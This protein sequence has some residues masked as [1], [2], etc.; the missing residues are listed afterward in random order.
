MALG[1]FQVA[2][3]CLESGTN[4]LPESAKIRKELQKAKAEMALVEKSKELLHNR[5]Y[6]AVK[7]LLKVHM[8]SSG[9]SNGE[10]G[11]V[12]DNIALLHVA[13]RADAYMGNMDASM[14]KV[15]RALRYNPNQ[16]DGLAVRGAILYLAGET[17][18]GLH[19]LQD[20]YGRDKENKSIKLELQQCH[21]THTSLSTGRSCVKRGRYL[22]A[23]EHFTAAM[24]E[25][26]L[27][28]EKTPLY[29]MVRCERAEAMMLS[30]NL[31]DAL[32][33]CED[34]IAAQPENAPAW[35]VRAEILISLGKAQEAQ[36][37]LMHIRRTWG[38]DDPTIEEGYR[39]VDFELR[40]LKAE[41][42]L[43]RFVLTLDQEL[44]QVRPSRRASNDSAI[45][46]GTSRRSGSGRKGA[47]NNE[48]GNSDPASKSPGGGQR[49]PDYNRVHSDR[50]LSGDSKKSY[51]QRHAA[52][53]NR[54]PPSTPSGSASR[55]NVKEK[56]KSGQRRSTSN[57][58]VS[59]PKSDDRPQTEVEPP[60][61]K[62]PQRRQPVK[63]SRSSRRLAGSLASQE[64]GADAG[65]GRRKLERRSG[66]SRV[67]VEKSKEDGL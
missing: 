21:R 28:P 4:S 62:S 29:A 22:E 20:A 54:E 44:G 61:P 12:T 24:K 66:S 51:N 31:D 53:G 42:E 37:E 27:V 49:R 50:R 64:G 8:G 35:T 52:D 65:G 17:E 34:V 6:K 48:R 23:V 57:D 26:T 33:D 46:Q 19:L 1:K 3:E 47:D 36:E 11:G 59:S 13:A 41:D 58:R 45:S 30:H 32:R 38:A 18:K 7:D 63:K 25:K 60:Q 67:L 10:S 40:V 16:A 14:E 5:E 55:S 2:L 15:N 39:R 43:D 9:K 56:R